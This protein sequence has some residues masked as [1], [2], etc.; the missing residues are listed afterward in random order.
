MTSKMSYIYRVNYLLVLSAAALLLQACTATVGDDAIVGNLVDIEISN[1]EPQSFPKTRTI[2]LIAGGIYS[3]TPN[4]TNL[5]AAVVWE[6][7]NPEVL[8]VSNATGKEGLVTS[9]EVG[10]AIVR[11]SVPR[12]GVMSTLEVTVEPAPLVGLT[13]SPDNF[14]IPRGESFQYTVA[15][16]LNDGNVV[17]FTDRVDWILGPFGADD[18]D[19][20]NPDT[21]ITGGCTAGF[22]FVT[23]ENVNTF[24][25]TDDNADTKGLVTAVPIPAVAT[26]QEWSSDRGGCAKI[27]ATYTDPDTGLIVDV[28]A[29]NVRPADLLGLNIEPSNWVLN[30]LT[31]GDRQYTAAAVFTDGRSSNYTNSAT[32]QALDANGN[33]ATNVEFSTTSPGFLSSISAGTVTISAADEIVETGE[34]VTGTAQLLVTNSPLVSLDITPTDITINFDNNLPLDTTIAL[35]ATGTYEDGQTQDLTQ[36]VE[37]SSSDLAILKV[38][39]I[40]GGSRGAVTA[41]SE[42]VATVSADLP[43]TYVGA[44][45]GQVTVTVTPSPLETINLPFGISNVPKATERRFLA[46]GVYLNGNTQNINELLEWDVLPTDDGV[47]YLTVSNDPGTKGLVSGIAKT[48]ADVTVSVRVRALDSQGVLLKDSGG[49]DLEGIF[50]L[51][52]SDPILVDFELLAPTSQIAKN[53]RLRYQLVGI[54]SDGSL[55]NLSGSRETLFTVSPQGSQ[56]AVVQDVTVV[57][58]PG[59]DRNYWGNKGVVTGLLPGTVTVTAGYKVRV[60]NRRSLSLTVSDAELLTISIA[61]KDPL[62]VGTVLDSGASRDYIATGN[63]SDGTTQDI[64]AQVVWSVDNNNVAIVENTDLFDSECNNNPIGVQGRV[65][66]VSQGSV[67]IVATDPSTGISTSLITST[68]YSLSVGP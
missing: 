12:S 44:P 30:P 65:N 29:L 42:G 28:N 61:P 37:W 68:P 8:V 36:W 59:I 46:S 63:F 55:W 9:V 31:V 7:L 16:T 32:W 19:S 48:P 41:L 3:H 47:T 43:V 5:T 21:Y 27:I 2:R 67:N 22:P 13:I 34:V 54:L 39:N 25:T 17:D 1:N 38:E 14:S 23:Q 57:N 51:N 20:T 11:A 45:Q 56:V 24:V 15:G 10:T 4:K 58:C 60:R 40:L 66:G 50:L 52:V 64:T 18:K 26:Y 33:I 62:V 6:S 35:K 49:N 53:T